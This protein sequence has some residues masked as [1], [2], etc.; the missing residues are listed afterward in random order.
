M[1]LQFY[2]GPSYTS[3]NSKQINITRSYTY[4]YI[5]SFLFSGMLSD[6][7]PYHVDVLLSL[8]FLLG[9]IGTGWIPWCNGLVTMA[10]MFHFQGLGQGVI[11]TCK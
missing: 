9:A 3:L 5:Y 2:E 8:A 10:V 7:F 6:C 11:D 4:R 1:R